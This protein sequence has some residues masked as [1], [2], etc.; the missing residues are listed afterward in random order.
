MFET[1]LKHLQNVGFIELG[2]LQHLWNVLELLLNT[3]GPIT[4]RKPIAPTSYSYSSAEKHSKTFAL[5]P[6]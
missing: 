4:K 2:F 6:V 3:F 1:G 5:S